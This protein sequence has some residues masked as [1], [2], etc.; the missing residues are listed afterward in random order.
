MTG[1]PPPPGGPDE[2]PLV[3]AMRESFAEV[4]RG[5][6]EMGRRLGEMLETMART[7]TVA[8]PRPTS[9]FDGVDLWVGQNWRVERRGN[10]VE[11]S[12]IIDTDDAAAVGAALLAAYAADP[13]Q[14]DPATRRRQGGAPGDDGGNTAGVPR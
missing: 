2:P 8:L 5:M 13:Q 12:G 14:R 3:R 4:G 10:L 6:A 9:S 7:V 11:V 1:A